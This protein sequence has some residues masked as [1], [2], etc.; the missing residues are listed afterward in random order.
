MVRKRVLPSG[1]YPD[2]DIETRSLLNDW[3]NESAPPVN[4]GIAGVV[5]HAGWFFSGSLAFRVFQ[6]L[7]K[8]ISTVVIIG[9]HLPKNGGILVAKD[10]EYETPLG[11]IVLDES[12]LN[13]LPTDLGIKEDVFADNT[14]EIQLPIVKYLFPEAK[15]LWMRTE[16]TM[17]AADLG[18]SL[19]QAAGELNREIAVIGSTDFTHYGLSYGFTPKGSGDDAY[20]WVT[21]ENDK[22]MVDSLLSFDFKRAIDHAVT[23]KAACSAGGAVAAGAFAQERYNSGSVLV[24]YY[25]SREKHRAESFVGY[26]GIVYSKSS[27]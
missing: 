3:E 19:A 17:K 22:K 8:E 1:W 11:N 16:P 27:R 4:D 10:D 13:A 25:T 2:T 18:K 26:A 5:P 23:N 15:L 24:D 6:C 7:D 12:L 20:R 14:V 9:G 21:E